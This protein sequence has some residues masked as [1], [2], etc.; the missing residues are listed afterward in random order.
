M[1]KQ[2]TKIAL[3]LLIALFCT[4]CN[5]GTDAEP[6]A[7]DTSIEYSNLVD[8]ASQEEI[9]NT[10]IQH[11]V[12]AE[13]SDTLIAWAE[14]FNSRVTSGTL[15]EGFH[16]AQA[17]D[18]AYQG[19]IIENKEAEDGSFAPEANC[20]L[21]SYL[22]MNH[23]I[24]TNGVSTDNDVFL[25]FDLEA[26]DTY[27]PFHLSA[28]ERKQF[29]TL[30]NSVSV[31]GANTLDEHIERIQTAWKDREIEIQGDGISLITVYLH[32]PFDTL[33]FVGHTGVLLE[34]ENGLIFLEKYGP[35]YPFQ[36]TKFHDRNE[37]K[38]YLL[39]R[40]DLYGDD[41]ELAPIVLE[42]NQVLS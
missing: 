4:G 33:R 38:H 25:M 2:L 29:S 3:V 41:T 14:D 13:Q 11:G 27:A 31:E 40:A 7:S 19:L 28:D 30:F 36:A 10:L 32:S 26:I 5:G 9:K 12:T 6:P 1:K 8:T 22:L 21:T 17:T 35:Q 37:L 20:R 23:L 16:T 24:E 15:P 39:S 34:T 18:A 42:N